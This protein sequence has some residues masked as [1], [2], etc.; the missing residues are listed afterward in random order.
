MAVEEASF[1]TSIV[2]M[3]FGLIELRLT[4]IGTPSTTTNGSLPEFIDATPRILMDTSAPGSAEFS[5]T[6]TPAIRPWSA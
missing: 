2:S 4:D 3:S 5:A 6:C 1:I